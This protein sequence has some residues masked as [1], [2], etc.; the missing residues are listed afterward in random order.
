M[1][2]R[3]V[4]AREGVGRRD[5]L[6]APGSPLGRRGSGAV[7]R[8][9]RPAAG[10]SGTD[11]SS[12]APHCSVPYSGSS[13]TRNS[14][15]A[16]NWSACATISSSTRISQCRFDPYGHSMETV[17]PASFGSE[18]TVLT[19]N[20]AP[21][22]KRRLVAVDVRVVDLVG[23]HRPAR[24]AVGASP[25]RDVV[26]QPVTG[27]GRHVALWIRRV[28]VGQR[29]SPELAGTPQQR[30]LRPRQPSKHAWSNS[31]QRHY[32]CGAR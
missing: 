29:R 28:R 32:A 18:R 27:G 30:R 17:M 24:C 23:H 25:V 13:L 1:V 16:M 9:C 14:L 19:S 31:W 21:G 2:P 10:A 15:G 3:R 5:R 7:G 26:L 8:R 4:L 6:D 12:A 20:V 22:S 11:V